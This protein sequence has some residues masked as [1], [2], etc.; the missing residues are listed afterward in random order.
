MLPFSH[1]TRFKLAT[2]D[3]EAEWDANIPGNG[4]AYLG[5]HKQPFTVAMMHQ[6]R[7]LDIIRAAA[8]AYHASDVLDPKDAMSEREMRLTEHCMNYM[9]QT[10]MCR[11][12][13]TIESVRN[14]GAH[15]AVSDISRSCRDWT[16]VYAAAE[17]NYEQTRS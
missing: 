6:L 16:S 15:R 14:L 10:V 7:C 11:A 12:D 8:V 5:E 9:R 3:G 17:E 1:S 2:P 4:V 13:L